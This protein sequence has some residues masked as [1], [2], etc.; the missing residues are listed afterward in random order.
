MKRIAREE[1]ENRYIDTDPS[2]S[3]IELQK[4]QLCAALSC[5]P[6]QKTPE[7]TTHQSLIFSKWL[8]PVSD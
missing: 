4:Q 1:A 2:E 3:K 8:S 7:A 5:W 6:M